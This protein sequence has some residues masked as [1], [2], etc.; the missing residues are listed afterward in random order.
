MDNICKKPELCTGCTACL[1]AC[2]KKCIS[3]KP[4]N[5]GFLYPVID[6]DSCINCNLCRKTCPV[7]NQ[8]T[9]YEPLEGYIGRYNDLSIVSE[10]T[11]GGVF[12]AFA[13]WILSKDGVICGVRI[14]ENNCIKHFFVDSHSSER[15]RDMRGSKYVQS[16]LETSFSIIKGYLAEGRT[17]LFSGTPCQVAG[18]KAYLRKDYSSLFTVDMVCRCA[19]APA[20]FKEYLSYQEEKYKSPI[21]EVRFRNKTYGYHSGSMKLEFGNGKI[22]YGSPRIDLFLNSFFNGLCSR[23]SC[24]KCPAK[25][26]K[27]SSDITIFEAWHMEQVLSGV[28]DDDKGYTSV[29]VRTENGKQ[30]L[31]EAEKWLKIWPANIQQMKALDGVMIDG[32]PDKH[33]A[34]DTIM[35]NIAKSSFEKAVSS[36][37]TIK[38]TDYFIEHLKHLLYFNSFTTSIT[39]KIKDMI[40]R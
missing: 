9:A 23:E 4:D 39:R 14:D 19:G 34:R 33:P 3:M 12:T 25:G 29:I 15:I 24:Y 17:V 8:P 27:K 7:N 26:D 35:E 31:K 37:L 13:N 28:K 36:A 10:S 32:Y 2:P 20:F 16:S 40:K 6:N 5:M 30:L 1:N 18:L 21:K 11:S 22:Y 38:Q